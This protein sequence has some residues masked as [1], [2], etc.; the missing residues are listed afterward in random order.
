MIT[1]HGK[2]YACGCNVYGQLFSDRR[3]YHKLTLVKDLCNEF[4]IDVQSGLTHSLFLTSM[5]YCQM[6][7][8][9]I[10][11][12]T[13]YSKGQIYIDKILL[14]TP[15]KSISVG[16]YHCLLLTTDGILHH[17]PKLRGMESTIVHLP[18]NDEAVQISAGFNFS[19]ILS[20]L[21]R[22]YSMG[23]VSL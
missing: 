4:I 16:M 10:G 2:V 11:D 6:I 21:G 1:K 17:C 9:M 13:V 12:G 15:M 22:V 23:T 20:K 18:D 5:V 8:R 14:N 19:C 7:N 3:H